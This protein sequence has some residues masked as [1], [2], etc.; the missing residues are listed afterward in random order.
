MATPTYDLLNSVTLSSSASSVT[1]SSIDQSYRD[2]VLVAEGKMPGND[3][4]TYQLNGVTSTGFYAYVG[5]WEEGF[6]PTSNANSASFNRFFTNRSGRTNT[7]CII[8]IMDYSAT[9]KHKTC[10]NSSFWGSAEVGRFADRFVSTSAITSV[11]F[12]ENGGA[13]L[14][15]GSTFYLYGVAA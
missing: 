13:N 15:A 3:F 5:M 2:L 8:Q 9:D 1:F 6:G 10:L 7:S 12:Q 14:L 11:S 4:L